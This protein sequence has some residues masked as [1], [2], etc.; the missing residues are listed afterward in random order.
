MKKK[1][2][3]AKTSSH[4]SH[5]KSLCLC[6]LC[7]FILFVSSGMMGTKCITCYS[8]WTDKVSSAG[9]QLSLSLLLATLNDC[10]TISRR[11]LIL[12]TELLLPP[13]SEKV[14]TELIGK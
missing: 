7:S 10:F 14:L 5:M 8:A 13:S 1:E 9:F 12:H 3:V 6:C 4:V 2:K 11:S